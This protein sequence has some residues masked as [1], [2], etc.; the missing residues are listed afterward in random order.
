MN[1]GGMI[2]IPLLL[3]RSIEF[4]SLGMKKIMFGALPLKIA[5]E[6]ESFG[7]KKNHVGSTDPKK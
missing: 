5:I 3:I 6:I 7:M 4:E 1:Y 2:E